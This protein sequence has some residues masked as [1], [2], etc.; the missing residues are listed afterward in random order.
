MES[1]F[2]WAWQPAS[3]V[4]FAESE[5]T[6]ENKSISFGAWPFS[7]SSDAV[8]PKATK[9]MS[10]WLGEAVCFDGRSGGR[11]AAR[12]SFLISERVF[13]GRFVFLGSAA[14]EALL[15]GTGCCRLGGLFS[16]TPTRCEAFPLTYGS[17]GCRFSCYITSGE[18][19]ASWE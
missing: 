16:V 5:H 12:A 7:P 10:P 2:P 8:C 14:C 11:L 18:N 4:G 6:Q 1:A 13:L 3:R 17:P 9:M 19:V 15:A